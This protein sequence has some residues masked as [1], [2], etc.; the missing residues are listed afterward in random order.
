MDERQIGQN[1]RALRMRRGLSLTEAAK[2]AGLSKGNLSK[3]EKA[4]VSSPI[5]TLLGVAKALDVHLSRFFVES[6]SVPTYVVTRNG[7]AP[8]IS[9]GGSDFGYSYQAL[10]LEMPEK[11]A[12]P[13]VITVRP[14]A[15]RGIFR[16][17]GQE[18]I[19][20][21]SGRMRMRLGDEPVI[22]EPGDS[23]YFDPRQAHSCE[24]LDR[25]T[26]RFLCL[27]IQ[28]QPSR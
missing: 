26:V 2:R 16:H 11:S 6:E 10:S 4:Q 1:I 21:L 3:I 17:E 27:F 24:A 22:L 12:E 7:E 25:K 5:A 9:R 20:I 13:F 28:H 15:K 23:L 18:F 19:H 8:I 14:G